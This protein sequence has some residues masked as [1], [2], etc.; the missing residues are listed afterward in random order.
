[1]PNRRT[2][3][4]TDGQ[5]TPGRHEAVTI[6]GEPTRIY[7]L[8]PNGFYDGMDTLTYG[9]DMDFIAANIPSDINMFGL[10]GTMSRGKPFATGQITGNG[11][12]NL[13]AGLAF[14][15]VIGYYK[16]VGAASW[17]LV[18]FDKNWDVSRGLVIPTNGGTNQ[19]EWDANNGLTS[20]GMKSNNIQ[21]GT[22]YRWVCI[23]A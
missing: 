19:V 3:P 18:F 22:A 9:I 10:Q 15:P 1:M 6:I 12:Q 13:I 20:D 4:S 2:M 5:P 16:Q 21:M 17:G 7:M 14:A 23:G 11:G 8:P